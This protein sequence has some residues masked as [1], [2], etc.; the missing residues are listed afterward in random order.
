MPDVARMIQEYPPRREM[1]EQ[2]ELIRGLGVR[3][4]LSCEGEIG[5]ASAEL[6]LGEGAKFF[7]SSTAL[8]GWRVQAEQGQAA[9]V[10][11]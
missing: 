3:L 10:Y 4:A 8:A 5:M 1:T 9:I 2:G 7:P 6:Q 11:E